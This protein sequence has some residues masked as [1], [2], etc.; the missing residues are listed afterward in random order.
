MKIYKTI[1]LLAILFTAC[2]DYFDEQPVDQV[3]EDLV[4]TDETSVKQ[5]IF[6]IYGTLNRE[7]SH[8]LGYNTPH[9]ADDVASTIS[10]D[11]D[12]T[13]FEVANID[14]FWTGMY[15]G[16]YSANFILERL[17]EIS[18]SDYLKTV[19]ASETRFLRAMA[20]YYLVQLHGDV[21][22]TTST[23]FEANRTETRAPQAE[24][25]RFIRQELEALIPGLPDE[26]ET[27]EE[28]K[29]RATTATGLGYLA[30]TQAILQNWQDVESLTTA[31]INN[32]LYEL[33]EDYE[34]LFTTTYASEGI[35]QIYSGPDF[36]NRVY[37]GYLNLDA[38]GVTII[39]TQ[40]LVNAFEAGDLRKQVV[41]L[42]EPVAKFGLAANKYRDFG[43]NTTVQYY[44]RLSDIYLLRAEARAR[45]NN[46]A[47]AMEDLNRIRNR[48][49]LQNLTSGTMEEAL[50]LIEHERL[51][52][53][54]FEGHR[55]FDLKRTGRLDAVMSEHLGEIWEFPKAAL[56]PVPQGE[57]DTNPNLLPNNPGYE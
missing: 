16:I 21:P 45:Q 10:D 22:L 47:G 39:P 8:L 19:Y 17:P 55:W 11:F 37:R 32:T 15:K 24:V 29:V 20:Y 27:V 18:M 3:T 9:M 46:L 51:V 35:F 36:F 12:L 42:E 53:L 49:G 1:I 48:A 56:W 30:K 6:G 5:A 50:L 23:N 14:A 26:Y 44:L 13:R 2:D 54:C 34:S 4:L 43:D 7:N 52:E 40:D 31:V 57:I 25:L 38:N 41:L 33:V 28:T